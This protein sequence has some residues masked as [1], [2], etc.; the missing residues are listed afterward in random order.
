MER[1]VLGYKCEK[2][3]TI[4][5]PNRARCKNC[6]NDLFEPVPLPSDGT[7]L[8]FTHIHNLPADYEIA[9]ATVGIVQLENG[10]R[11]TGQLRIANPSIGMK[12]K[13]KVEVVRQSDY[14]KFYGWA[15][16]AVI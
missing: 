15:F 5:Y 6:G 11:V 7:L 3:E 1:N 2:C 12:L 10:V 8:T 16:Y 4:H 9:K 13:G 14:K